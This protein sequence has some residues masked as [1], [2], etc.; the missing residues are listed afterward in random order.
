MSEL[1]QQ[2][3]LANGD[4]AAA[5]L[6]TLVERELAQLSARQTS[7][8]AHRAEAARLQRAQLEALE[9]QR[10]VL[11]GVLRDFKLGVGAADQ[12]EHAEWLRERCATLRLKTA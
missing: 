8:R 10:A 4:D 11:A 3:G 5:P 12:A 1:R 6:S 9:E 7:I 2:A